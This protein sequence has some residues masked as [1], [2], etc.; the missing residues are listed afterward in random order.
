MYIPY[1][2]WDEVYFFEQSSFNSLEKWKIEEFIINETLIVKV[3]TT[4]TSKLFEALPIH[5]IYP[6]KAVAKEDLLRRQLNY[7]NSILED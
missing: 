5:R 6:T 3:S 4:N 2:I 7:T 1:E